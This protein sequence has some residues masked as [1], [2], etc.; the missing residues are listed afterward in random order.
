MVESWG[1]HLVLDPTFEITREGNRRSRTRVSHGQHPAYHMRSLLRTDSETIL[2]QNYEFVKG[3]DY[4]CFILWGPG[5]LKYT[6]TKVQKLCI[7]GFFI[8]IG[9]FIKY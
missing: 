9:D 3:H 5:T 7:K 1:K 2:T 4:Q 6:S 8:F